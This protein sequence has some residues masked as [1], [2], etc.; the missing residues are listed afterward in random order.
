MGNDKIGNYLWFPTINP[1]G[2][3]VVVDG[4]TYYIPTVSNLVDENIH[5]EVVSGF[6]AGFEKSVVQPAPGSRNWVLHQNN[7]RF[8]CFCG[9]PVS[10]GAGYAI[11][12][13]VDPQPWVRVHSTWRGERGDFSYGISTNGA[14]VNN[15]V[16]LTWK[17]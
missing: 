16:L 3:Q 6:D 5:W 2:Q 8:A 12:N 11:T 15:K 14:T 13:A 17:R 9:P 7:Q 10:V 4:K 1:K